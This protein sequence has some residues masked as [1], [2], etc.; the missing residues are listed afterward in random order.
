MSRAWWGKPV[1]GLGI[2]MVIA[3]AG[4][5]YGR[6]VAGGKIDRA[7]NRQAVTVDVVVELSFTPESYHRRTLA[8]LGV[9]SGRVDD[10]RKL[11]RLLAVSQADLERLANLYWVDSIAPLVDPTSTA[12]QQPRDSSQPKDSSP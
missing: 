9:Y 6:S 4:P 1:L 10:D 8:D 5:I 7:I 2:V 3:L 12:S 11:I